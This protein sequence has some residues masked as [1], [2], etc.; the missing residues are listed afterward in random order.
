MSLTN[1][2]TPLLVQNEED[3]NED[4]MCP[5]C[6][7]AIASISTKC[8]H[9]Y[10]QK[11]LDQI[12]SCALCRSPLTIS[13]EKTFSISHQDH[14]PTGSINNPHLDSVQLT[15]TQARQLDSFIFMEGMSGIRYSN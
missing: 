5:I 10:C 15:L 13:P 9:K 7:D 6:M 2:P 14:Q 11:C 1:Q 3:I 12:T 8:N 4:N